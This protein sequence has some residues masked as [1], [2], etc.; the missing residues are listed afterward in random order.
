M[1][2]RL[3]R[4]MLGSSTGTSSSGSADQVLQNQSIEHSQV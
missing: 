4:L 2:T 3:S 1:L